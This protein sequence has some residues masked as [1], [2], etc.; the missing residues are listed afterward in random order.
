MSIIPDSN[1]EHAVLI[2]VVETGVLFNVDFNIDNKDLFRVEKA[3]VVSEPIVDCVEEGKGLINIVSDDVRRLSEYRR[4]IL[5]LSDVGDE[6]R[7]LIALSKAS[8][9]MDG[10]DN[11][12]VINK[13][14]RPDS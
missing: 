9:R 10:R 7:E 6:K 14:C 5:H 4:F 2:W 11:S 12:T 1:T 13:L 8:S 3:L